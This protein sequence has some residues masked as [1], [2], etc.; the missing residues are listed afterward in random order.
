MSFRIRRMVLAPGGSS[1][2]SA[3]RWMAFQR[4]RLANSTLSHFTGII[5]RENAAIRGG[6]RV[7]AWSVTGVTFRCIRRAHLCGVLIQ[8]T[9]RSP[10]SEERG[11]CHIANALRSRDLQGRGGG[12]MEAL[13]TVSK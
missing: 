7:L 10:S 4:G 1:L 5:C 11:D 2:A 8:T 13:E 3:M 6:S 9:G 12:Q